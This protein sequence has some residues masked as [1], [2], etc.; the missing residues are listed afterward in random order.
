MSELSLLSVVH[1]PGS[2]GVGDQ[3][4][5]MTPVEQTPWPLP[6]GAS[7]YVDSVR[8]VLAEIADEMQRSELEPLLPSLFRASPPFQ[9]TDRV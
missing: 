2:V 3:D 8:M 4:Q 9:C 7:A 1:S 5:S 6:R